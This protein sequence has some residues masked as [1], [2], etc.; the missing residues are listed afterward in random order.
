MNTFAKSMLSFALGL[1]LTTS[2][3]AQSGPSPTPV[4]PAKPDVSKTAPAAPSTKTAADKV[5]DANNHKAP[6]KASEVKPAEVKKSESGTA[7]N[8]AKDLS[9]QE[10][11][12][13]VK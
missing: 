10:P 2:A 3:F 7:H 11:A 4:A 9:K 12:R 8:T 6:A 1:G 5:H 13:T